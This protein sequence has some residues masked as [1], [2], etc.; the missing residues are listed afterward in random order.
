M[1]ITIIVEGKNDRSR[2]R[3]LLAPEVDILCTF[4]TLNTLKLESLRRKAGDDEIYLY[5]DNDSSGK[6]IRGIL[7]DA[8]PDAGHLYTRRGYAGVEGT[9]EEYLITQLEKAGLEEF[10]IYPKP[11]PF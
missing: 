5:M 6:R 11:L 7:R 8:F 1:T 2:L 4:G 9:P 10:I 3:R